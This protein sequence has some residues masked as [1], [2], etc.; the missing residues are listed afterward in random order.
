MKS[1]VKKYRKKP[2]II[3]A[4]QWIWENWSGICDFVPVPDVLYVP[5]KEQI[6]EKPKLKLKVLGGEVT[7]DYG[8]FI[9]KGVKG[10]YYPIKKDIFEQTYEEIK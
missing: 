7:V 4:I 3:E 9:A 2:I 10:E 6:K 8:D 1:E 5:E